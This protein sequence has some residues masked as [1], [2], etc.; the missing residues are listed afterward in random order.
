[1][2]TL[3]VNGRLVVQGGEIPGLDVPALVERADRIAARL[4]RGRGPS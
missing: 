3:I 1:V 2:D 4:L